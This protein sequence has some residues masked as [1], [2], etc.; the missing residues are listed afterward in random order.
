MS[1]KRF[2]EGKCLKFEQ[3]LNLVD[4]SN[5]FLP[6][7]GGTK[8]EEACK[9]DG[10]DGSFQNRQTG[11]GGGDPTVAER[12]ARIGGHTLRPKNRT[13]T[14]YDAEHFKGTSLRQQLKSNISGKGVVSKKEIGCCSDWIAFRSHVGEQDINSLSCHIPDA[15]HRFCL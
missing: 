6:V 13:H 7:W 12:A 8:L 14:L 1:G 9:A 2:A 3:L 4:V 10:E 5:F 11:L 15:V